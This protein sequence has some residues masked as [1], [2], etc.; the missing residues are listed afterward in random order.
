MRSARPAGAIRRVLVIG[1]GAGYIGSALIPKLL[2]N[3]Y[4]CRPC[5]TSCSSTPEPIALL[6]EHLWPEV[7]KAD[8]RQVDTV[9]RAVRNV[10]VVIHLGAIVGDPACALDEELTIEVKLKSLR[11]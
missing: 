4:R 2:D 9:V 10:D 5:L 11:G 8:F 1:V 7:I 6:S 3:G